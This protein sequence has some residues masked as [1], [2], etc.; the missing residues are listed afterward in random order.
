MNHL[1]LSLSIARIFMYFFLSHLEHIVILLQNKTALIFLNKIHPAYLAC[2]VFSLSYYR[3]YQSLIHIYQL[4]FYNYSN[5][6]YTENTRRW[7]EKKLCTGHLLKQPVRS[8]LSYSRRKG[9]FS[10]ELSSVSNMA[11]ELD[12]HSQETD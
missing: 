9:D 8:Y 11:R 5:S 2:K 4:Q 6:S 3:S 10:K 7:H 12:K 1:Q